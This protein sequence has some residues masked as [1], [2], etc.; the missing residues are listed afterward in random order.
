MRP[1]GHRCAA[2]LEAP[3]VEWLEIVGA[4][5]SAILGRDEVAAIFTAHV[6]R[7]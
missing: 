6:R 2:N 1:T 3:L 5:H 4:G 7:P